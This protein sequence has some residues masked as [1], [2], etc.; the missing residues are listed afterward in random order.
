MKSRFIEGMIKKRVFE[1]PFEVGPEGQSRIFLAERIASMKACQAE[2][3]L[4]CLKN[5]RRPVWLETA[6]EGAMQL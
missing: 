5:N 4:A 1:A 2:K 6:M 3:V